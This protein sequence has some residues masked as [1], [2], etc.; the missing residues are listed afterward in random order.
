MGLLAVKL[1]SMLLYKIDIVEYIINTARKLALCFL[2][3]F[4][5]MYF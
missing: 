2:E 4:T 1:Y 3:V 5:G